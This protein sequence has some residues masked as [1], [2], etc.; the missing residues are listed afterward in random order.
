MFEVPISQLVE[1]P[2]ESRLLRGTDDVFVK[3]LKTRMILDPSTPGATPNGFAVQ[4]C[5]HVKF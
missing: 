5:Y 3:N 1:P 4:G 2:R